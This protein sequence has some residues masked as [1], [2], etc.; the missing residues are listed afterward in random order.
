V[1]HSLLANFG[2]KSINMHKGNHTK[3]KHGIIG[4]TASLTF[5]LLTFDLWAQNIIHLSLFPTKT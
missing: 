1:Q 2:K 3:I 4:L 5:D